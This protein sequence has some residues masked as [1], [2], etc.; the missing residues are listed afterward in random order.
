MKRDPYFEIHALL[1]ES[2]REYA[3][4][5]NYPTAWWFPPDGMQRDY[6]ARARHICGTCD[7]RDECL[8]TALRRNEEG[9]WGGLNIKERRAVRKTRNIEKV[10]V[11]VF[12][13]NTFQKD[14]SSTHLSMFCS[15]DCRRGRHN[16]IVANAK[17]RRAAS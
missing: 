1:D 13:R 15:A 5:R 10:L 3:A 2:W 4:C 6:T 11:C 12:C 9:I 8:D 14:A 7:V 17:R 16:H